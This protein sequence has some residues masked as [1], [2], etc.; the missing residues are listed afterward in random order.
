MLLAVFSGFLACFALSS[1]LSR[2]RAKSSFLQQKQQYTQALIDINV[3]GAVISPG[4][5]KFP[6][7][8]SIK[9][10]LGQAGLTA[11]ADRKKINFKRKVF[12]SVSLV[13]PE[14]EIVS[15]RVRI[16]QKNI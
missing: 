1:A 13:V 9:E 3:T 8:I 11:K 12:A 16:E 7:G 4:V 14:K 6:P 10:I 15:K 5:Y 2:V